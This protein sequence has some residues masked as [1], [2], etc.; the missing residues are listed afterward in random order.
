MILKSSLLGSSGDFCQGFSHRFP[1]RAAGLAAAGFQLRR[2]EGR[3]VCGHVVLVSYC[4]NLRRAFNWAHS[5]CSGLSSTSSCFSHYLQVRGQLIPPPKSSPTSSP[6]SSP[7]P[8]VLLN[9]IYC[10]SGALLSSPAASPC[11]NLHVGLFH[12]EPNVTI[13]ICWAW[14]EAAEPIPRCST[15][16]FCRGIF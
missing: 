4:W 14:A 7:I 8:P 1:S 16:N 11:P 9:R 2:G 10:F 3:H 5:A 6:T 15:G 12:I 13:P